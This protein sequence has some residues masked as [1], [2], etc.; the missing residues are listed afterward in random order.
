MAVAI[1]IPFFGIIGAVIAA[2]LY[3]ISLIISV[4]YLM[5]TKYLDAAPPHALDE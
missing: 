2:F 5:Q 4:R 3:R 1:L